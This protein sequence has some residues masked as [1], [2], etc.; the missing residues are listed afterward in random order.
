MSGAGLAG[1]VRWAAF[2]LL[3]VALIGTNLA[4]LLVGGIA[5]SL[6]T[7]ASLKLLPLSRSHL[8]LWALLGLMPRFLWQSLK[9]GWD[10]AR[11][12]LD[13]R[14][15]LAPG[16]VTFACPY[17]SEHARDTF[18]AISSLLPGTVPCGDRGDA[19]EIH[20]LDIGQPVVAQLTEE[21]RRMAHALGEDVHG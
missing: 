14:L 12:A 18:A 21:A 17:R 7:W 8:R 1:F 4:A 10:V 16:F 15:P 20:C 2:L 6:A 3:W 5:A 9:A 13:P 19:L 11:R